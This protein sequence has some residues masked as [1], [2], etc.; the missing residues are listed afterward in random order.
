M[1]GIRSEATAPRSGD[2][3]REFH[4]VQDH[5]ERGAQRHDLDFRLLRLAA[6]REQVEERQ[7]EQEV[8]AEVEP[9]RLAVVEAG[10]LC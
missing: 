6:E 8:D 9:R 3:V 1:T 2:D 7:A 4:Q 5:A 10:D